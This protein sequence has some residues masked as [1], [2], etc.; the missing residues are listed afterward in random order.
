MR[1][2]EIQFLWSTGHIDLVYHVFVTETMNGLTPEEF[3][4][5]MLQTIDVPYE[6]LNQTTRDYISEYFI[7]FEMSSDLGSLIVKDF[8]EL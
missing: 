7:D 1:T 2:F 6:N 3:S 5:M 4:S 8:K